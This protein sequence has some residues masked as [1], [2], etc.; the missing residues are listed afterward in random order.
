MDKTQLETEQKTYE[1]NKESLVKDHDGKFVLI[2][3]K[4]VDSTWDSYED[5]LQAGYDR[6]GLKPFLV[7]QIER[8]EPIHFFSRDITACQS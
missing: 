1:Q 7:K 4:E 2:H 8:I 6:F 5:A 3:E